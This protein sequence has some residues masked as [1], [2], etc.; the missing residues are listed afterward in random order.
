MH[1]IHGNLHLNRMKLTRLCSVLDIL[2]NED[3]GQVITF[4][5]AILK[6]IFL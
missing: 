4:F 1:C 2:D 6:I 5:K 3:H